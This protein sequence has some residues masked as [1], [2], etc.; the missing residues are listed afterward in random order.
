[1][2]N[3]NKA[4]GDAAA[5]YETAVRLLARRAHTRKELARKLRQR[6]YAEQI[7]AEALDRC[8]ANHYIDDGAACEG[9]CRELIRKGYGPRAIRRRLAD[10]GIDPGLI[11]SALAAHYPQALVHA[12][13]ATIARRK[14]HQL[15]SR[16]RD[17]KELRPRLKRFLSQRGFPTD[18]L[19]E[20]VDEL[21]GR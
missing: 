11:G 15:E 8:E 5:A 1:M 6:G 3:Q 16:F 12:T 21:L 9:Y 19:H 14:L 13:A 18:L 20:V 7:S 10:R 4:Q 17:P 2:E